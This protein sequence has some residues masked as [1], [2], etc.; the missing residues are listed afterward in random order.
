MPEVA[1]LDIEMPGMNGL[2]L[3]RHIKEEINPKTNIIFT[4]GFNEHIEE[5]FTRLRASGYLMKPITVEMVLT[6]LD[7]LRYPVR[8]KGENRIRIRTF[9]AFE[10]YVDDIPVNFYYGKTKELCAYRIDHGGRC[11]VAELR[12][13][14]WEQGD[15]VADHRSYLQNMIS[16]LTGVLD[17]Y[18]LKEVILRKYGLIGIDPTKVDCDLYLYRQGNY[19]AVNAFRGEYIP[20]ARAPGSRTIRTR[21]LSERQTESFPLKK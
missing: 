5:A 6:E 1:F 11:P 7:N 13:N 9:G 17:E 4:T 12:E 10:I 20:W 8:L 15:E 14:L 2:I 18:G 19:A 3:A 16:D 21:F